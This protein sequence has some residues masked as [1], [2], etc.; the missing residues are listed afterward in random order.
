MFLMPLLEY[1]TFG[2]KNSPCYVLSFPPSN[3]RLDL[4]HQ[5]LP[6][7]QIKSLE[8][9]MSISG[10][11]QHKQPVFLSSKSNKGAVKFLAAALRTVQSENYLGHTTN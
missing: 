1:T 3:P 9:Q 5:D 10:Q 7:S 6:E 11:P 8:F 2:I 4:S